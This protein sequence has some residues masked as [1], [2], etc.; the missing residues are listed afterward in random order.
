LCQVEAHFGPIGDSV[1]LGAR[2]AYV[3]AECTTGIE[4]FSGTPDSTSR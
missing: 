3:F 2:S 4:I 1:R